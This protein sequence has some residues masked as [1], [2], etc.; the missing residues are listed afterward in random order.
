MAAIVGAFVRKDFIAAREQ[1][2][3]GR[4]L[5]LRGI[6]RMH[7]GVDAVVAGKRGQPEVGDDEPLGRKGIDVILGRAGD[8]RHHDV[9]PRRQRADGVANG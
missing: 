5:G 9:N 8:L 3:L 2:H 1:P 7:E 6:E 4:A